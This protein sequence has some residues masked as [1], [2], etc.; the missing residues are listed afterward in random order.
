MD[1]LQSHMV[2]YLNSIGCRYRCEES[3]SLYTFAVKGKNGVYPV[4]LYAKTPFL[5]CIA[6]LPVTI[7]DRNRL[8]VAEYLHRANFGLL[9]G[10]FEM[11]YDEGEVRF[12]T[13]LVTQ[14]EDVGE[15]VLDRYIQMPSTMLDK[16]APGIYSIVYE[17]DIALTALRA[18]EED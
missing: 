17:G 1:K 13:A 3:E 14:N 8:E 16:Y 7:P 6:R 15:S 5:I 12:R 10:S 2:D 11:D 4:L 18:L 9:L